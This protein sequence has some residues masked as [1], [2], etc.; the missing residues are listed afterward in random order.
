VSGYVFLPYLRRGITTAVTVD[1][2]ALRAEAIISLT[3]NAGDAQTKL[4][5]V[6]PGDVIGLDPR[7]VTRVWPRA[8]VYDAASNYFPLLELDQPDLPWRYSPASSDQ[9]DRLQPWFCLLALKDGEYQLTQPD[10]RRR[11]PILAIP[12]DTPLPDLAQAWAW[13]HVQVAGTTSQS[14]SSLEALVKTLDPNRVLARMLCPRRLES[15]K[16][17]TVFLVPTFELGRAAGVEDAVADST[18]ALTPAWTEQRKAETRLP[19]YHQWDF[20][21]GEADDFEALVRKIKKVGLKEGGTRDMDVSAPGLGLPWA[22]TTP[23]GLEGAL[24]L[25][26]A[27]ATTWDA[28]QQTTWIQGLKILLDASW[29]RLAQA[30]GAG[31]LGPPLYGRW[32]A[33]RDQLGDPGSTGPSYWFDELNADP[34]LRVVAAIGTWVVQSRQDE[35]M[36]SAWQQVEGIRRL[37]AELKLAQ[38]A[39]EIARRVHARHLNEAEPEAVLQLTGPVQTRVWASGQ[40]VT[41]PTALAQTRIR[42]GLLAPQWRRVT[43]RIGPASRRLGRHRTP[44]LSLLLQHLEEG[45]LAFARAPAM[46]AGMADLPSPEAPVD[47]ATMPLPSGFVAREYTY[48]L[49]DESWND[50]PAVGEGQAGVIDPLPAQQFRGALIA[51]WSTLFP[52]E[53]AAISLPPAGIGAVAKRLTEQLDPNVTI[54]SLYKARAAVD[55]QKL[56]WDPENGY[57][58]D[59][60][61]PVMAAPTF[62]HPM[63]LPLRDLS[64]DWLFPGLD[65]VPANSMSLLETNR[66]FI[67]A[68]MLGLNHEMARE[69]LWH[70]YPTDQ[71]GTYF[72][73]F[74]DP[75]SYAAPGPTAASLEDI[76]PIAKWP[77]RGAPKSSLDDAGRQSAPKRQLV[78]LIRG[79][80]LARYPD[81]LLYASKARLRPGV[82]E[83][84]AN[85]ADR[86][87]REPDDT[88]EKQPLFGGTLKPDVSFF[89]FD[90]SPEEALGNAEAPGGWYFMLQE[91]PSEMRFNLNSVTDDTIE[92]W[93]DLAWDDL[94]QPETDP[95]S[96][97]EYIHLDDNAPSRTPS[98]QGASWPTGSSLGNSADLAFILRQRRVR[99]AVHASDLIVKP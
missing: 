34:R 12:K 38:A 48:A 82:L 57:P 76:D 6:G 40:S 95:P 10:A 18:T 61:E 56:G 74:W 39:R 53:P 91:Q 23:L 25:P 62:P 96:V 64:Q 58:K 21:S 98:D 15:R 97:I 63:Y 32:H 16:H 20:V 94:N 88:K 27:S 28:A 45:K 41:I 2:S 22:S 46:P 70:G 83:D 33:G 7:T 78:L 50:A 54:S 66:R 37:N 1:Q 69:L 87:K 44:H 99:L 24:R 13:A 68:Y 47:P 11:V 3:T 72:R 30:G 89:A 86:T 51:A 35:L 19:V 81:L 77:G 36:E 59:P 85:W 42:P 8:G 67:Y 93:E 80:L 92:L 31:R 60:L 4:P 26:S 90:I 17:Y 43:R 52:I 73:Q 29:N 49:R 75:A 55:R 84:A 79:D 71:R 9:K 65:K 5:L 14:T